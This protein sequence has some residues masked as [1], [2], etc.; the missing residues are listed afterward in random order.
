MRMWQWMTIKRFPDLVWRRWNG[1][2]PRDIPGALAKPGLAPRFLG[3]RSS[4]RGRHRNTLSRLFFTADMLHDPRDGY[5]L[6]GSAF[7][8]QDRHTSLFEREM[9]LVPAAAKALIRL[10]SAMTSKEIQRTAKRLNHIG[11]TLVFEY[12]EERELIDLLK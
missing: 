6:A 8:M 10:T 9:G 4:L 11:S 3:N 1:A 7:Q 2:V 5:R 12:M